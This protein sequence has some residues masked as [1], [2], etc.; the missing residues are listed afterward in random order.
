MSCEDDETFHLHLAGFFTYPQLHENLCNFLQRCRANCKAHFTISLDPNFDETKQWEVSRILSLVDVF[1][2]N[3]TEAMAITKTESVY[4]A[5]TKLLSMMKE[6]SL[7]IITRGKDG[8]DYSFQN[9]MRHLNALSNVNAIDATGTGDAF[10]AGFLSRYVTRQ[11][12]LEDCLHLG[13]CVGALCATK[14]GACDTVFSVDEALKFG[15]EREII[16]K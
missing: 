7:L 10:D 16:I 14:I 13:K 2:P 9:S 4:E 5:A 3:E 8:L 12:P 15:A 11:Y 6:G 1:C